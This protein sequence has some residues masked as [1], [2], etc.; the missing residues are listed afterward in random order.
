MNHKEYRGGVYR[1]CKRFDFCA[2]HH[3]PMMPAGH[4][5]ARPHG[6]NYK[7]FVVLEARSLDEFG[8]VTDFANLG[9]FKSW[10]TTAYD[11]QDLTTRA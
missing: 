11:H 8:M 9:V 2:A 4:K 7:V 3:L 10:L 1:I 5:C 6:H